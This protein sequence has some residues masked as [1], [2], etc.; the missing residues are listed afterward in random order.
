[1]TPFDPRLLIIA[2]QAKVKT[3]HAFHCWHAMR[4]MG[5]NFHIGAFATFAGLECHH[6]AAI[7]A[8]IEYHAAALAKMAE[9]V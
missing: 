8:A 7:M 4:D 9:A 5:G 6:V 3:C 2:A 1:M